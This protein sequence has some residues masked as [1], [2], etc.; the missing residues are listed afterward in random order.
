[1]YSK[2]AVKNVRKS[3]K[4]YAIYFLTLT[5]SVCI[6][7]VF[8]S[9]NDQTIMLQ[10]SQN[11]R[12]YVELLANVISGASVFI[13]FILGFLIIYANNFLIKRRKKELGVYLC[14]G[15][16]KR[17]IAAILF[18]ETLLIGVTSLAT[19]IL[20]GL[21]LSQGLAV[22]TANLFAVD[23][24]R[25]AFVF[26]VEALWKTI[27]CFGVIFLLVMLFNSLIV[28]KYKLIDLIYGEKKNQEL[29]TK[30]IGVSVFLFL[31]SV[32]C[33]AT[34]Y[35]LIIRNKLMTVDTSFIL[36]LV[37]GFLG[38]MLFFLSLS[39]FLLKVVQSKKGFYLKNLNMFVLRQ[40]NSKIN[41]TFISMGVICLML[42]VTIG[43]L[44]TG[45]SINRTINQSV[46]MLTP[47]D[48]SIS[49]QGVEMQTALEKAG[50]EVDEYA[51]VK[52]PYQLYE[53]PF[54][55]FEM[56]HG[57]NDGLW[58]EQMEQNM[59]IKD[60][61]PPVMK[62]SDYNRL[63]EEAGRKTVQPQGSEYFLLG[64]YQMLRSLLH[65]F[66]AEGN[67]LTVGGV[68]YTP[69]M[70]EEIFDSYE[71][72]PLAMN[73]VTIILPDSAVEGLPIMAQGLCLNF[74]DGIDPQAFEEKYGDAFQTLYNTYAR[75]PDT[76]VEVWTKTQTKE[77][78]L[79]I[80][81]MVVY[82]GIYIGLIFL[83][84]SVAVLAIQQ[85][86]EAADN[87]RRFRILRN[88]GVDGKMINHA[89]FLQILIYFLMPL[90]LA[91]V[92]SVVGLYVANTVVIIFGASDITFPATLTALVI[93]L[94]YGIYFLATYFGAKAIINKGTK[95]L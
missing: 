94:V 41:T 31:V 18:L 61:N 3:V 13:A 53:A 22:I 85:L 46:R 8:N 16:E 70:E 23:M 36:S 39:G 77:Q 42:F 11:Q 4:D 62:V 33:L 57:T 50:L 73:A 91:I 30:N 40:I 27:A 56:F 25:F 92:H 87:A 48:L 49:I 47:Y 37:L 72:T 83:I 2:L 63:M 19:G 71:T 38:T 59:T 24:T 29:K 14:L 89:L 79:G 32:A 76:S 28:S 34:A 78:S 93:I 9:I 45:F 67:T 51:G 68:A 82:M 10:L 12:G 55:V 60:F 44:A 64:N 58:R 84:T 26:S 80:S 1:M 15:M 17:K 54:S 35:A 88:I 20:L 86:S 66:I 90:L 74:K 81:T 43:M 65:E 52:V 95:E 69:G 7:Y 6:F 75:N 5:V 21:F